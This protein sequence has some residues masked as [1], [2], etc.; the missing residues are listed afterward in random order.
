M[1]DRQRHSGRII[2]FHRRKGYGF[3]KLDDG[4]PDV[5]VGS[6]NFSSV[7]EITTLYIDDRISFFI[8]KRKEGHRAE[9]IQLI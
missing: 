8:G 6:W 4:G 9:D 1:E 3:A 7:S 5:F 2:W